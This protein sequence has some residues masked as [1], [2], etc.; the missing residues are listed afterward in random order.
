MCVVEVENKQSKNL[1]S[2]QKLCEATKKTHP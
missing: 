1:W 2:C